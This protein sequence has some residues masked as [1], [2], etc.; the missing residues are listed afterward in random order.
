MNNGFDCPEERVR[1]HFLLIIQPKMP[2]GDKMKYPQSPSV[3]PTAITPVSRYTRRIEMPKALERP[4]L[5]P[6]P[7]PAVYL[8]FQDLSKASRLS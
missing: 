5:R 7:V 2:L 6:G 1:Q 4:L 3:V 8:C